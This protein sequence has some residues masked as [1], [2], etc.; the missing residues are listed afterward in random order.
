MLLQEKWQI[1]IYRNNSCRDWHF[2]INIRLPVCCRDE[3]GI[4]IENVAYSWSIRCNRWCGGKANATLPKINPLYPIYPALGGW[5]WQWN[6][7]MHCSQPTDWG[8]IQL[9]VW[10]SE[11]TWFMLY[12]KS[13][14]FQVRSQMMPMPPERQQSH[15]LQK[16]KNQHVYVNH[17]YKHGN[18][19]GEENNGYMLA[20]LTFICLAFKW[21][22]A[23]Q[24]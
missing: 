16:K 14:L 8:F 23:Q 9:D 12:W 20:A 13:V 24:P 4:N 6:N 15:I 10:R 11:N 3:N 7:L 21:G 5:K 17:W 22:V 2:T 18:H 1:Q 19:L